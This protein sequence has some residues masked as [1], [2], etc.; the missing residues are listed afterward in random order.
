M[1]AAGF[2]A[3]DYEG[4]PVYLWP[5]CERS[6]SLFCEMRGQWRCDFSGPT[7]LD[8]TALFARMERMRLDDEAW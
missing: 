6:W 4:E 3:D 5:E 2:S 7:A 1:A 8:Y